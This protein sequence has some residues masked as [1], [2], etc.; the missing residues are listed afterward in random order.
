MVTRQS[1][2][3]GEQIVTVREDVPRRWLSQVGAYSEYTGSVDASFN[4]VRNGPFRASD[5]PMSASPE[6]DQSWDKGDKNF[7]NLMAAA[8][9]MKLPDA[10]SAGR[11]AET[12]ASETRTK[13]VDVYGS[14]QS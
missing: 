12:N 8:K 3:K 4:L 7:R 5:A 14:F 2:G 1:V 10:S 13:P 9:N 11:D 6:V